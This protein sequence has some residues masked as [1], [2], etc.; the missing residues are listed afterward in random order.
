MTFESINVD[1]WQISINFVDALIKMRIAE[2]SSKM[3]SLAFA[4]NRTRDNSL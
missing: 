2:H 3:L 1:T 4:I